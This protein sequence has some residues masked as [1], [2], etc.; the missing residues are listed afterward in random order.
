[1]QQEYVYYMKQWLDLLPTITN[2]PELQYIAT[3]LEERLAGAYY[4]SNRK[5]LEERN[6]LLFNICLASVN[7]FLSP[8]ILG[9][10]AAL[11]ASVPTTA[12]YSLT[13]E[14]AFKLAPRLANYTF[15]CSLDGCVHEC[16]TLLGAENRTQKAIELHQLF[17]FLYWL[18]SKQVA[19]L[20]SDWDQIVALHWVK[21]AIYMFE[22]GCI[23]M[24]GEAVDYLSALI[25]CTSDKVL[26]SP[27]S[28]APPEPIPSLAQLET[29]LYGN[30]E[31]HDPK[32]PI[33][34]DFLNSMPPIEEGAMA[35][36]SVSA[37]LM[38][39]KNIE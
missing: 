14:D 3:C 29:T 15:C 22:N 38:N 25:A 34:G 16:T 35:F 17:V 23:L 5:N 8:L 39:G 31:Q 4:A 13:Y 19:G 32:H 24:Q 26:R 11:D 37:D 18:V 36:I 7:N 10:S 30:A 2:R 6:K 1:M 21:A 9:G 20:E 12:S 28:N 27:F 33:V